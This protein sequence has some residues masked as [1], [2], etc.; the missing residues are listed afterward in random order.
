MPGVHTDIVVFLQNIGNSKHLAGIKNFAN[1]I[2]NGLNTK[3][4]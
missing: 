4:I 3:N 2:K 1:V